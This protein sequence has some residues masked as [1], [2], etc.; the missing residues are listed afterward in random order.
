M[1]ASGDTILIAGER[2]YAQL[3]TDAGRTFLPLDVPYQ[4][5]FFTAELSGDKDVLLAGLRGNAWRSSDA[6]KSWQQLTSPMPV[7]ITASTKRAD[8]TLI[9]ANQAGIL[10]TVREQALVPANKNPL[11]PLNGV[12]D[13]NNGALLALSI[14]GILPVA[15]EKQ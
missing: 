8:G 12:L 2:G 1:R 6:G 10:L 15:G 9:L 14:Q 11:P 13:L 5:S 3:S 4:G 7:T